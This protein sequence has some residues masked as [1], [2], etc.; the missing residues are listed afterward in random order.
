[1]DY[2][3]IRLTGLN[4]I[5]LAI[6]DAEYDDTFVLKGADGLGPAEIDVSIAQGLEGSGYY[7][8][9]V[10]RNKQIVMRLGLNAVWSTV[11]GT[12]SDLRALLYGMLTGGYSGDRI[13]VILLDI[14]PD[15]LVETE[16]CRIYGYVNK[17]ETVPFSKD[18]QVQLTIECL[19]PYFA[20]PNSVDLTTNLNGQSR[21]EVSITNVGN[22]PS[23]FYMVLE[24]NAGVPIGGLDYFEIT[25]QD[26]LKKMRFDPPSDFIDGHVIEIN[27]NPGTRIA[28]IQ[29]GINGMAWLTSDSDWIQL[30]G[31]VNLLSFSDSNYDWTAF[32]FVPKFWGV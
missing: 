2:T 9:K 28:T 20:A 15:T 6:Q 32:S 8:N 31:G 10:P 12:P 23:G 25:T 4:S 26:G 24:F 29:G 22:G 21:N 13:A 16:V 3:H 7:Q 14:D 5:T 11:G 19:S 1:M 30:Q 27:T 17:M 18:P